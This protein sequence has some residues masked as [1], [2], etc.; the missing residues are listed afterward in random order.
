MTPETTLQVTA[1]FRS[2]RLPVICAPMFLVSGPDLV[3]AAA[4][5][6]IM[7]VS[8]S[9][10]ARSAE[11]FT[12]WFDRFANERAAFEQSNGRP[13]G[14]IAANLNVRA[15]GAMTMP[16]YLSDLDTCRRHRVPLVITVNGDP[17]PIIPLVHDWGGLVFHDVTTLKHARRAI[18][19]GVD[20]LIV[21]CGGGGGHSGVLNPF[22]FV[23]QL[24][25]IFDGV[26][27]LAGAIADGASVRAAQH[28]GADLCYMGT[29]FI[30]TRESAAPESYKRMLV[31]SQSH[32]LIYT[33]A[34]THGV[35]AMLLEA[36]VRAHGYDPANLPAPRP[37][38]E[39]AP[40]R[41]WR[42]IW[43]AGQS[44]GLIDD[45]PTVAELVDRIARD[46]DAACAPPRW[47][48]LR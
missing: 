13:M 29:R 40:H 17:A 43:A 14:P 48:L 4:R 19:A 25:R 30:A 12:S 36:S 16:R 7:G 35:P 46:Y 2:M 32:E 28:L 11:E 34:F 27:V 44:V 45:I 3:L 33:P 24:R 21:I 23:P 22:A 47:D 1:L 39:D 10:T 26:I 41:A 6:G 18:D 31:D 5:A 38:G 42:D 9:G 8:P 15:G 37:R 20:G